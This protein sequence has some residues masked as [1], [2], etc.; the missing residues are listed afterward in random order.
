[1]RI[2]FLTKYTRLGASSRYR[3]YQFLPWLESQGVEVRVSPLLGDSYLRRIYGHGTR[4]GFDVA[5]SFWRRLVDV[6]HARRFDLLVVEK[7]LFPYLPPWIEEGL[8]GQGHK[9]ITDYDDAVY[10]NYQ[11][12]LLLRDKIDRVIR[13]STAVIVGN[14]YLADYARVLNKNVYILPTA[15]D[16]ARYQTIKEHR[17]SDPFVVGWIGTPKTLM[18]L[19]EVQGALARLSKRKSLVLRCVGAPP[20]FGL[21]GVA[22]ENV[23]WREETETEQLLSMDVGIMPLTDDAFSRGK[24]GLKLIQYMASGLP[25]VAS[26]VGVN[27]DIV[28]DG[29]NGFLACKQEEWEER[30]D[31]LESDVAIRSRL[32]QEGRRLVEQFYSLQAVAPKLLEIYNEVVGGKLVSR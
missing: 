14:P 4:I 20:T 29:V 2:L 17:R 19:R 11:E 30:L 9:L 13:C 21:P 28:K 18:Y 24:C 3:I 8:V 10:V 7:E 32:G 15:V 1:M 16:L 25:V 12:K 27:R 5:V 31:Q 26:P 6:L 23:E 22:V